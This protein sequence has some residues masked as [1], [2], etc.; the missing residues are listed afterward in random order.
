M[1]P[2]RIQIAV[3]AAVIGVSLG[4]PSAAS[5]Q[6]A[7]AVIGEPFGVAHIS[8]PISPHAD[9]AFLQSRGFD[10]IAPA[11]RVL[12]PAISTGRLGELAAE[13]LGS[14]VIGV[15]NQL[16]VS[17]LFTGSEPFEVTVTTPQP[18]RVVVSP[19]RLRGRAHG[20]SL[21][22]WWRAYHAQLRSQESAGDYPPLVETYLTEML[23]QRL[24]LQS[25][26]PSRLREPRKS[27]LQQTVDLLIG[28]E[29]LRLAAL[30]DTMRG[31]G[32]KTEPADIPVPD[33]IDWQPH[34]FPG[35]PTGAAVESI[36][37]H[38]PEECFYVRFGSFENY[39][40][41]DHLKDDYGGDIGQMV[42]LRGHNAQ[43][44]EKVQ[45]QL[46]LT[47][48]AVKEFFGPQF[49]SDV[50][51]IGR[52]LYLREGAAL[53]MLFEAK[54]SEAL[55]AN[56][57]QDR[58][59]FLNSEKERGATLETISIGGHD[60][61]FLSTPDNRLRSFYAVDGNYHLVT[62]SRAVVTRF[63]ETGE[64]RGALGTTPEFQ[65]ARTV[66]PLTR[67]DT[68]FAYFSTA[69]FGGLL[70]PQYQVALSRRLQR[71]TH[72]DLVQLAFLAAAAEGKPHAAIDDLVAGRFLPSGSG[73]A[74]IALAGAVRNSE[75]GP[76]LARP[77]LRDGEVRPLD[78]LSGMPGGFSSPIP[79]VPIAAVTRTEAANLHRSAEYFRSQW[80]Q[81]DPLM[82]GV[83]RYALPGERMERVVIDGNVSPFVEDK[84]GWLLSLIGPP[85]DVAIQSNPADVMTLQLSLQG[86][87]RWPNIPAHQLFLGVQ[88]SPAG[89]ELIPAGRLQLLSLLRTTPGY[90]GAWPK[91]G[92]IDLLPLGPPPDVAGFSQLP[93]GLWRWQGGGFSVLAFQRDVLA[94]AAAH[95]Q[96]AP[97]ENPAQIR[98]RVSDLRQ[99]QLANWVTTMNYSRAFQA[100]LGNAH[101][102]HSLSQQFRIPREQTLDLANS[103]LDTQL[104]CTLGGTYAVDQGSGTSFWRSTAWPVD[105]RLPADYQAPL[106]EW[107]RG[108][109][110]D[111]TKTGPELILHAEIDMERKEREPQMQLPVFNLFKKQSAE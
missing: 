62:T 102:L 61:S 83:K 85:T 19:M 63:L 21:M 71:L 18:Q 92:L 90:L 108:A 100:S 80:P 76:A 67:E 94:D 6:R 1:P 58:S 25:P 3:V 24:G 105:G 8:V 28:T 89:G 23:S 109:S 101:L 56:I 79:D 36:A 88:D 49:I 5:A 104:V 45:Y 37:M 65:H 107:F 84:Y 110:V 27:E 64:G 46:A 111:V 50:A 98:L 86:G 34:P 106:L 14:D 10:I 82:I 99:S 9:P 52:D 13:L 95:L 32:G 43:L 72:E 22:V 38:V 31:A 12:Y 30:R 55:R 81:M 39:V 15:P 54:N 59:T 103:L 51:L 48:T 20:A 68:I 97:T 78:G 17:F 16:S 75:E 66:M 57:E 60:V 69:F 11:G 96:P 33:G 35:A 44:D 87:L 93:F 77:G 47:Q 7:R 74:E 2:I 53:G 29:D 70:S 41:M 40:W 91:L 4:F 42:T 73:N 26:L